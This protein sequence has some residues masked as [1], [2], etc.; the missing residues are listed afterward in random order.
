[1]VIWQFRPKLRPWCFL[2]FS[3]IVNRI[4]IILYSYFSIGLPFFTFCYIQPYSF[5]VQFCFVVVEVG[6]MVFPFMYEF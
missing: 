5:P 1:M 6:D 4:E 2:L 3:Y